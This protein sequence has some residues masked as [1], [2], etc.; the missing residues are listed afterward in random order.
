MIHRDSYIKQISDWKDKNII[1]VITGMRRSGKTSILELYI[2]VL[3][4]T[5]VNDENII[6]I[7][8]ED[9]AFEPYHNYKELYNFIVSHIKTKEMYYIFLDEIQ[10]VDNFEKAI[11]SLFLKENVDIYLTGS[12]AKLLSSE[13]ST[14]LTGRY[15]EIQMYPLSFSEYLD[16][17]GENNTVD[18]NFENYLKYGGM[19][20]T[21]E[22]NLNQKNIYDYLKSV[23]DTVVVKDVVMKNDIKDIQTLNSII[24]FLFDNIGNTTSANK[25]SNTLSSNGKKTNA[26]TVDN[27]IKYLIDSFVIYKVK[28]FD[29]KGKEYLKTQEKYYITDIGLRNAILGLRDIDQGHILENIVFLELKRRGYEV[30]IGKMRD[31]EIDFIASNQNQKLY[32]QVA[33]TV[34]AKKTLDRELYPLQKIKDSYPKILITQ[35]KLLNRDFE[36][37]LHFNIIDFLL[38]NIDSINI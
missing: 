35:D 5:G 16:F 29:I 7:N 24:R 36:G 37:I 23:F 18:T 14:L 30:S 9:L 12:N 3:K 8:F 15:I 34:S 20:Y 38:S 22:L 32:I 1:K 28:R 26:V 21:T 10:L 6:H 27:Y 2:D 33:L 25:I 4:V 13:I 31:Y 17:V 19:P 11:D